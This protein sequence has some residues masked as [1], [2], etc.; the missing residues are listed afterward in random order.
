MKI[1]NDG[2]SGKTVR[3]GGSKDK[4]SSTG[5]GATESTSGSVDTVDLT[6][7]GRVEQ[8]MTQI[9]NLPIVNAEQVSEIRRQIGTGS[10]V[11]D[12][13]NAADH[14]IEIEKG[15]SQQK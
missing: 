11:A 12:E 13:E 2:I 7:T 10:Y 3:Q 6:A 1:Q 9:E 15:F 14:I 5:S 4:V 8:L